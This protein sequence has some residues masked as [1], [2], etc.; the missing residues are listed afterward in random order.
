MR[1]APPLASISGA[2]PAALLLAGALAA[3]SDTAPT[4]TPPDPVIA[5]VVMAPDAAR[6]TVPGQERV[7]A[8][9]AYDADFAPVPA[10]IEFSSRD[11]DVARVSEDGVVTATGEGTTW[12]DASAGGVS[13]SVAIAVDFVNGVAKPLWRFSVTFAVHSSVPASYIEA[14]AQKALDTLNAR[15]NRAGVFEGRFEFYLDTVVLFNTPIATLPV[16]SVEARWKHRSDYLVIQDN[17]YPGSAGCCGNPGTIWMYA[18]MFVEGSWYNDMA[19]DVLVHEFGHARG[20]VDIYRIAAHST[21]LAPG[22][23]HPRES[24]MATNHATWDPVAQHLIN[25]AADRY[26]VPVGW[27]IYEWPA[28]I[29]VRVVD[30][31]DR[32]VPDARVAF[33]GVP[34]FDGVV[35]PTPIRQG[36]TNR[37]GLVVPDTNPYFDL[38]PGGGS[39]TTACSFMGCAHSLVLVKVSAYGWPD[40]Y[41]WMPIDEVMVRAW[42]RPGEPVLWTVTMGAPLK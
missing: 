40:T 33:H 11:E 28:R 5:R 41:A 16:D 27:T 30:P 34:W 38:G 15:F 37:D 3:C 35:D 8:A 36:F 14:G 7:Y 25:A 9:L 39:S 10:T 29:G 1:F 12:I 13:D 19:I 32:P 2:R 17:R 20:A 6:L 4:E 18:G 23:W 31:D 21:P 24:I 42:Q 22:G 26:P